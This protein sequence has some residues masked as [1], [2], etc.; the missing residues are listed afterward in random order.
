MYV[1]ILLCVNKSFSCEVNKAAAALPSKQEFSAAIST[2][3]YTKL[4]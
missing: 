3:R 4:Q 1:C 2:D